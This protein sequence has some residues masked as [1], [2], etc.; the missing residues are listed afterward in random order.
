MSI[1]QTD[2]QYYYDI[3]DAIRYKN[4][5]SS[6]YLP[7]EMAQKI[8]NIETGENS[9]QDILNHGSV[10]GFN[11]NVV[12][13]QT[14]NSYASYFYY[15]E[16]NARITRSERDNTVLIIGIPI[17]NTQYSKVKFDIEITNGTNGS[18]NHLE[19]GGRYFSSAY[20]DN[21][22]F[23]QG[24]FNFGGNMG[25][26]EVFDAFHTNIISYVNQYNLF[27]NDPWYNLNRRV[28]T[29]E[30]PISTEQY[31]YVGIAAGFNNLRIYSIWLE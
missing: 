30:L 1:I 26:A 6:L 21:S 18:Y 29:L 25:G 9:I 17:L 22:N 19:I 31:Y 2:S 3:A 4:G 10:N 7:S 16:P 27:D 20:T 23:V 13:Y 11:K 12:F 15:D 28:V 24:N 14:R 5:E 8:R